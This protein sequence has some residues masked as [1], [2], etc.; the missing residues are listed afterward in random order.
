MTGCK[1]ISVFGLHQG[2]PMGLE[3]DHVSDAYISLSWR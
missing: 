2:E 1:L 3:Q